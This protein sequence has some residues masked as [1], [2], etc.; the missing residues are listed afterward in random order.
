MLK[1]FLVVGEEVYSYSRLLEDIN[2]RDKYNN[3]VFI[4][5]NSPYHIFLNLLHSLIHDYPIE[6]LDGNFSDE[7]IKTIGINIDEIK[8][9]KK[10]KQFIEINFF[11]DLIER[12]KNNK[13][14][15][16]TLYTSGTT[17]LPKKVSHTLETIT[18]NVKTGERFH[19][20]VWG[21]AYNPTHMAGIQVFLQAIFNENTIVYIFGNEIAEAKKFIKTYKV[22]NISA[23]STFYKKLLIYIKDD[24]FDSVKYVTFGGEKYD[25]KLKDDISRVFPNA[26]I[27]NIYASTEAGSLFSGQG[28]IFTITEKLKGFVKINDENELLIHKSLLGSSST[29]YFQDNWYNTKDIVQKIDENCFKFVSRKTDIINIGGYKVNPLEIEDI[30]STVQDVE[31]VKV[32]ARKN[33]V[34]GNIIIADVVIANKDNAKE[35]KQRILQYAKSNLQPWKIPRLINIVESISNTRTGKK[36]R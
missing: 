11:K 22:T 18:R 32:Y 19:N 5:D 17:G 21:F 31:D 20:N 12:A 36:A 30:L 9:H 16:I 25:S 26:K 7:E 2:K 15:T 34:T 4:K 33:S 3:Y 35:I 8:T 27:K 6:I 14:W 23:T 28:E 24:T 29:F 13:N 10:I 1:D